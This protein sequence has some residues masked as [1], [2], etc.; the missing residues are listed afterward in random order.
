ML[1]TS[2]CSRAWTCCVWEAPRARAPACERCCFRF[3]PSVTRCS[4]RSHFRRQRGPVHIDGEVSVSMQS[5]CA[6]I[7]SN[8]AA[9]KGALDWHWYSSKMRELASFIFNPPV[10]LCLV[11]SNVLLCLELTRQ[12]FRGN[13]CFLRVCVPSRHSTFRFCSPPAVMDCSTSRSRVRRFGTILAISSCSP[14]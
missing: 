12:I 1:S 8:V 13:V 7:S 5:A 10:P 4:S 11:L 14:D 3:A 2:A 9:A 6:S